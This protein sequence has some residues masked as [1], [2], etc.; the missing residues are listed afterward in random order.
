MKFCNSSAVG[1]ETKR[2]F[3]SPK[4]WGKLRPRRGEVPSTRRGQKL[5]SVRFSERSSG[6][7]YAKH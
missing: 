5:G 7:R 2:A 3:E 6:K 1:S 4:T